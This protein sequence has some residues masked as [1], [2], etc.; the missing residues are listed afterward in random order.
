MESQLSRWQDL[1]DGDGFGVAVELFF[2]TLEKVPPTS[3]SETSQRNL[4]I[5]AFKTIMSTWRKG[6]DS[7]GTQKVILDL[8]FDLI[9]CDSPNFRSPSTP[10]SLS[11]KEF[12]DNLLELLSKLFE[13]QTG[14]HIDNAVEKLRNVRREFAE[15][16]LEVIPQSQPEA[17]TG[18]A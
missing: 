12:K 11:K 1:R 18:M 4:Y 7:H 2:I 14:Q 3:S 9:T 8:I 13:G 10:I 17:S 15:R 16:A 5:G 6:R